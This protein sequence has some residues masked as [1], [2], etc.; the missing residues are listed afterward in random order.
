M[1]LRRSILG[2]YTLS[3]VTLNGVHWTALLRFAKASKRFFLNLR[4]VGVAH[5]AQTVASALVC[6]GKVR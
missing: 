5:W 6:L 2:D 4:S 1:L 3:V